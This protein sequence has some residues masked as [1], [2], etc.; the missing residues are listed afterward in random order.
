MISLL[1]VKEC[2]CLLDMHGDS[3][4]VSSERHGSIMVDTVREV[5]SGNGF[6]RP[7]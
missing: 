2:D 4:C 1:K 3:D 6:V 7:R 5:C